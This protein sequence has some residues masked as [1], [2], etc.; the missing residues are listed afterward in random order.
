[1]PDNI[2]TWHE[3]AACK[4]VATQ[5][6]YPRVSCDNS[7]REARMICAGCPVVDKCMDEL[8]TWEVDASK[9]RVYGF[10][11]GLS[12]AQRIKLRKSRTPPAKRLGVRY[13]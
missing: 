3:R 11:A 5:V 4:G 10:R 6:F 13:A 9:L 12:P 1:M 2:D 7:Y 8:M